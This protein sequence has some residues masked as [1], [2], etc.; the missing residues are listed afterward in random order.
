MNKEQRG[1]AIEQGLIRSLIVGLLQRTNSITEVYESPVNELS[2]VEPTIQI[3]IAT[4]FTE[5][6]GDPPDYNQKAQ[7]ITRSD[8]RTRQH[9]AQRV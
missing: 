1:G 4:K 2:I 8:P 6:P 5:Y 3:L 9:Q 7:I